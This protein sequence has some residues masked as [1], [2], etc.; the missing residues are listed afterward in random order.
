MNCEIMTMNLSE[1]KKKTSKKELKES[2]DYITTIVWGKYKYSRN[3][4]ID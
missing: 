2:S 3:D 4:Y 1:E